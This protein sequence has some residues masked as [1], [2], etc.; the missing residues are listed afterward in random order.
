MFRSVAYG[1]K[2]KFRIDRIKPSPMVQKWQDSSSNCS[3]LI[4]LFRWTEKMHSWES[5][6]ELLICFRTR[7]SMSLKKTLCGLKQALGLGLKDLIDLY[8]WHYYQ[9]WWSYRDPKYARLPHT[10][11]QSGRTWPSFILFRVR[12]WHVK[13][14]NI[15]WSKNLINPALLV[16]TRVADSPMELNAKFRTRKKQPNLWS[17]TFVTS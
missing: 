17:Y 4:T 8:R 9:W 1:Y 16:N 13:C 14:W 11:I 2:Q 5:Y 7:P 15:S 6:K 10:D 3:Y 12:V